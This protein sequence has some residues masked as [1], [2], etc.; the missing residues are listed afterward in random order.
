MILT[1]WDQAKIQV[2]LGSSTRSLSE[3][4]PY[5]KTPLNRR[6]RWAVICKDRPSIT[7]S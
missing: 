2:P 3:G 4:V 5:V 1:N 7:C 6:I